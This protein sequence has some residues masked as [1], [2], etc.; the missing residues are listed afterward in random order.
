MAAR[1][2]STRCR[3]FVQANIRPD[4]RLNQPQRGLFLKRSKL[5]DWGLKRKAII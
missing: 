3:R 5:Y 2:T 1:F 4:Y